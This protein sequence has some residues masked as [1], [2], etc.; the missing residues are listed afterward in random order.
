MRTGMGYIGHFRRGFSQLIQL[1]DMP[2]EIGTNKMSGILMGTVS[3]I[4]RT[5]GM[6]SG[7]K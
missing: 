1:K 6:Y 7:V 2:T 5:M 4:D 3:Q